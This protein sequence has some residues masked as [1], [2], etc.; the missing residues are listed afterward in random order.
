MYSPP[1]KSELPLISLQWSSHKNDIES[2]R[3][4]VRPHGEQLTDPQ[5]AEQNSN[6]CPLSYI[7]QGNSRTHALSVTGWHG[8]VVWGHHLKEPHQHRISA[9]R[10]HSS[11]PSPVASPASLGKDRFV[12]WYGPSVPS[13]V[14]KG[15]FGPRP[16][17]I[18][19]RDHTWLGWFSDRG[20]KQYAAMGFACL[21]LGRNSHAY[22][23]I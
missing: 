21:C 14:N 9:R 23:E 7:N 6:M 5:K 8:T 4:P 12:P 13:P 10:T 19:V 1:A 16:S 17:H 18:Y 15:A 3:P 11:P 22:I 20:E 2:R